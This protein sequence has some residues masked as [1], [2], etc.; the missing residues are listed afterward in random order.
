MFARSTISR[1]PGLGWGCRTVSASRLRRQVISPSFPLLPSV[2]IHLATPIDPRFRSSFQKKRPLR[3]ISLAEAIKK[4]ILVRMACKSDRCC[5]QFCLQIPTREEP[6]RF[7]P[8]RIRQA[9]PGDQE[10][11]RSPATVVQFSPGLTWIPQPGTAYECRTCSSELDAWSR[12]VWV[13]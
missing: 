12:S 4:A 8:R 7:V 10:V 6:I 13:G 5:I 9:V 2:D 1:P 3:S 11:S